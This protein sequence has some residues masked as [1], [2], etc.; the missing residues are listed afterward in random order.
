MKVLG[1]DVDVVRGLLERATPAEAEV[2]AAALEA[3]FYRTNIPRWALDRLGAHLW[4]KQVEICDALNT[5]RK[6]AVKACH[7]P[8]KS[9]VAATIVGH[10][11]DTHPAGEAFAVTSA[12]TDP[13]VKAILWRE[14]ARAHKRGDLPGRVTLDAQWK[15][16]DQLVAFGRKPADHDE[17]GFQGIHARYL[18]VVM[19]EACGIPRT[20]WTGAST[21]GTNADARMLAIGNPDDPT[22][23]FAAMCEGAPEDGTSGESRAG[24]HVITI[25]TFDT[26]NFTGEEIPDDLRHHLP[27]AEWLEDH[28]RRVGEGSPLWVSK[29]LG[30]FPKDASTG[31][32]P[33]SWLRACTGIDATGRVGPLEVPVELGLDVAGSDQGDETVIYERRGAHLGRRWGVQSSDPE[34]V[35]QLAETA[36]NESGATRVKYDSIGVGWGLGAPLRRS[37]PHVEFV[38]VS[39]SEAAPGEDSSKFVNLRAWIWWEVGRRLSQ[40][41]AWDLSGP[42]EAPVD[43]QTLTELA[44]PRYREVNGRIQVESKDEIRKRLGRS[45]DN[46]DA[47]LLAFYDPPDVEGEPATVTTHAGRSA[48]LARGR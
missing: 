9:Y 6:V 41:R 40:D 44:A 21:L 19:D 42:P 8:G 48:A 22:S 37:F 12:P 15:V 18:L 11:I 5:H 26:P 13:Q 45:T 1:L 2:I 17:H 32:V 10:W 16:D 46:A 4:S 27:S 30:Q 14:I 35:L 38:P 20:L 29:V 36:V 47:V 43:D 7:G 25:S 3:E 23:E 28:R 31:V 24:W 34:V 39:V 33:W